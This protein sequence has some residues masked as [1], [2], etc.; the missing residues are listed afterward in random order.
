MTKVLPG[1][2]FHR[3]TDKALQYVISDANLAAAAVKSHNPVAEA[4]YLDQ[5]NDACT[6]LA[7]R[8]RALQ[9]GGFIKTRGGD[10]VKIVYVAPLGEEYDGGY[11]IAGIIE[12]DGQYELQHW[13]RNGKFLK[14]QPDNVSGLDLILPEASK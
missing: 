1:H 7:E 8:Q 12:E 2:P 13:V 5:F 3:L 11:A 9:A 6:I 4:K 14:H 10:L